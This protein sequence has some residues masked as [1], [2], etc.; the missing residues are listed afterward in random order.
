MIDRLTAAA[1]SILLGPPEDP[2][3][4]MGAVIDGAAREKVLRYI[5]IGKKEGKLLLERSLPD[6]RGH[7]VP[8]TIFTDIRP[9]D[10][11]AQEEIFGPLLAVIKVRDFDEA[12]D[13]ANST[14]YALTGALFSR[15]PENIAR[16]RKAFR[17]GNLYIN[18]GCTGSI[19]GRHP[20]GGFKLSGVGVQDRRPGLSPPVH[21][22]PKRG[23]KHP[24]PRLRPQRRVTPQKVIGRPSPPL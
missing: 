12:L 11:I 5:G 15:S 17:V 8:L 23:G 9:D 10:R 4:L 13:V 2:W 21:G 14:P 22:P 3:N 20:F 1:E 19:V 6:P 7:A 24:P 18:S 16:A